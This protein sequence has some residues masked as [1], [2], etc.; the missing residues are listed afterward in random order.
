MKQ[1]E[2]A[3]KL[4]K[5]LLAVLSAIFFTVS[6]FSQWIIVNPNEG[7]VGCYFTS[8][9]TGYV[10]GG[11]SRSNTGYVLKTTDGGSTWNKV[12]TNSYG[13]I[14]VHF[15]TADIG[16][17]VGWRGII[18]KTT[19]AGATWTQQRWGT[20]TEILESVF[21][22]DANIGYA[23]GIIGPKILKTTDGGANWTEQAITGATSTYSVYFVDA[24]TGYIAAHT[25]TV[26]K[27]TDGD[28]TW[29]SKWNGIT[30][31]NLYA[32]FF[33]DA[34]IGYAVG[35]DGTIIKTTD[36]AATW[37][38]QSSVDRTTELRSVWFTDANTGYIVGDWGLLLKTTDGGTTWTQQTSGTL[39][40]LKS[41]FFPDPNTGY[42]IGSSVILKTG[43][44]TSIEPIKGT[45][46][47]EFALLQNYPNP[48]NPTTTIRYYLPE[49]S[50]VEI[51]I[52]DLAGRTIINLVNSPKSPGFHSVTWNGYTSTGQM[53][54]A[55]LYFYSIRT[56]RYQETHKMVLVK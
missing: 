16:Y 43:G 54:P 44:G 45:D 9:T 17:A 31:S 18:F 13:F 37:T 20:S 1:K 24:N 34:N 7:G 52:Y 26:L 42:V 25:G 15:P 21:F 51:T 32:I 27:T 23:V 11:D 6:G 55:G 35:E 5:S 38:A 39:T 2:D 36:G 28:T 47:K 41:I 29:S 46:P 8:T 30:L 12:T 48:F 49:A 22:T 14:A 19:D 53:A 50:P 3:M 56:N 10:V 33:V 4:V 40:N